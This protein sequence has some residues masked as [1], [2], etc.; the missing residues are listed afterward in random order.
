M[1]LLFQAVLK[2]AEFLLKP[3]ET[4]KKIQI[5]GKK[6]QKFQVFRK[7]CKNFKVFGNKCKNLKHLA[8]FLL[9]VI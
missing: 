1:I 3:T 9:L 2:L 8:S 4:S 5:F 7:N 6:L